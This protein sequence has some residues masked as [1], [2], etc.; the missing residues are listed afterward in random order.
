MKKYCNATRNTSFSDKVIERLQDD[1]MT[2]L[3]ASSPCTLVFHCA[4]ATD[5]GGKLPETKTDLYKKLTECV[6]ARTDD[7]VDLDAKKG[8]QALSELAYY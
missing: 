2:Q 5:D 6:L 1:S 8:I 3:L 7:K 4:I